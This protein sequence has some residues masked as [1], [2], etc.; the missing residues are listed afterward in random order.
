MW[1]WIIL[2][3]CYQGG[4][5]VWSILIYGWLRYTV[6]QSMKHALILKNTLYSPTGSWNA[7]N[8]K[9]Q[10]N[11]EITE[12][13]PNYGIFL[14]CFLWFYGWLAAYSGKQLVLSTSEVQ[15]D[16]VKFCCELKRICM[17]C[18]NTNMYAWSVVYMNSIVNWKFKVT[19]SVCTR[20]LSSCS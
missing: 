17:S 4:E 15:R 1:K 8:C 3:R 11:T 12:T 16:Q 2:A 19:L 13:V 7:P 5:V 10:T 9:A 14:H 18:I 6:I 20:V